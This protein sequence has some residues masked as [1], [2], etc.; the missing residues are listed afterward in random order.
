MAELTNI[1]NHN[2]DGVNT[3]KIKVYNVIPTFKMT[4]SELSN[5]LSRPA[6]DGEEFNNFDGTNYR[7]YIRI[8][9]VWKYITLT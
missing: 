4:S 8:N 5:Y 1:Q 2:H 7:K 9:S 6:I 3:P